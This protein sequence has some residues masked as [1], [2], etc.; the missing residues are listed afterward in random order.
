MI[1]IVSGYSH[2][3][4]STVALVNLCNQLNSRGY[5]SVLYG[6]DN[7]HIGKCASGLLRD[8]EPEAGDIVI[9]HDINLQSVSELN[10]LNSI[11]SGKGRK[12]L[13]HG[14]G[15]VISSRF[16]LSS[17]PDK[18]KLFL[19]CQKENAGCGMVMRHSL[20]NKIHFVSETQKGFSRAK[21]RK[22]VCPNFLADL[23]RSENKSE[24]VAGVI[25]SI[26]RRNNT[27]AI[28]EKALQDGM[29][30]V[31]LYGYLAD[32]IYYY[33]AIAPLAKLHRGKIK[34]AG[35]VENQ[36]KMYDSI[37]DAYAANSSPWSMARRECAMTQT[38]FHGPEIRSDTYMS[39]DQ[40]FEI[41][42]RE[43]EL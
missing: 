2:P 16:S 38:R 8:F 18:F 21:Q 9:L 34:F 19:T 4:G 35:F 37:S 14:F 32:P 26:G 10:N 31:I 40:I 15:R 33:S 36:Q 5:S 25:G 1:K 41:W 23:I 12:N 28:I 7:W 13:L 3:A 24:R 17:S 42:K 6:P 29:E 27:Q 30:T 43:L 20:F 39:N 22:F 11:L